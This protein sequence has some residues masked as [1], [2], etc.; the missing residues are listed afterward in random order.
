MRRVLEALGIAAG[1]VFVASRG[2]IG[3][4]GF[5]ANDQ[6]DRCSDQTSG[7]YIFDDAARAMP[8]TAVPTTSRPLGSVSTRHDDQL[9]ETS[10]RPITPARM[11]V[12]QKSRI[13]EAASPSATM[14]RIA[15]P[16]APMPVQTA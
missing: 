12:M 10:L 7:S 2:L 13:G 1:L 14:P 8:A 6:I 5:I 11:R 15:V 16:A 9:P 4:S 3:W